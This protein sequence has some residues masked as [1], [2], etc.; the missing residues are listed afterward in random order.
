MFFEDNKNNKLLNLSWEIRPEE[1]RERK[2][3][4]LR[5]IIELL[6]IFLGGLFVRFLLSNDYSFP[7][8]FKAIYYTTISST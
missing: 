5:I 7:D 3:Q 6:P 2:L 4:G 8:A 1:C